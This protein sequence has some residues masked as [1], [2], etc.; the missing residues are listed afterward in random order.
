MKDDK[1]IEKAKYLRLNGFSFREISENLGIAKSTASL[2]LRDIKLSPKAKKRIINLGITGRI[3]GIKTN[4]KKREAIDEVIDKRA[5]NYLNNVK[6]DCKLACSLLYWCE[7]NK[8]KSNSSVSFTNSDPEMINYFL[9]VFRNSFK[10]DEKKFRA[11]I[12]LHEYHDAEKQLKFWSGIT[13][14]TTSQ[15]NKPYLK[16]NTGKNKRENYPGCINI[17]YFDSKIYKELIFISKKLSK[18]HTRG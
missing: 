16:P 17:K 5:E 8:N 13:K 6:I 14:I 1:I 3:K 7:G 4:S 18:L 2:W 15:F 12:H 9:Y 10:L 11:L